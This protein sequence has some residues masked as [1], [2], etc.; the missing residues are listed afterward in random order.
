V[1]VRAFLKPGGTFVDVG[2]NCGIYTLFAAQIVGRAGRVIALEPSLREFERLCENVMLNRLRQVVVHQVAAAEAKGHAGL[3]IAAHQFCGHNT[4]AERFAFDR[5]GAERVETVAVAALDDVLA[6]EPRCD[7]IKLDIEGAEL[8]ALRGAERTLAR[9]RPVVLLEVYE[10]ALT[11]NGASV[12]DL[13]RFF[14]THRYHL[15]DIDPAGGATRLDAVFPPAV[16]KN[17]VALPC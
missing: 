16:N 8:R 9:L 12:S 4:F 11:L 5:V 10:A 3:L 17:V 2:A 7:M 15:R 13:V 14:E 1:A 6:A